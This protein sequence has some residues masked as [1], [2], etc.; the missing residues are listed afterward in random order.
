VKNKLR[1]VVVVLELVFVHASIYEHQSW[2]GT[3]FPFVQ[4]Y[5][6]RLQVVKDVIGDPTLDV[7]G[8]FHEGRQWLDS[9]LALILFKL[10]VALIFEAMAREISATSVPFVVS[11]A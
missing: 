5:K 6:H 8:D 2:P 1:C 4:K 3:A 7:G 9:C 11:V 10:E